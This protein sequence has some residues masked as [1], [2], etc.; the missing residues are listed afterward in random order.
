MEQ[1]CYHVS[2]RDVAVIETGNRRSAAC[3]V[4]L[5]HGWLD[6]A[7]S[8]TSVMTSMAHQISPNIHLCAVDLPGHGLSGHKN[9]DNF[10]SF[11]DYI[12][13]VHQF[14]VTLSAKKKILVGHSLGGLIASCYSAAFPEFVDGLFLIESIGPLAE[15]AENSVLRLRNGVNS[16]VRI[17][18]KPRRGYDSY[19]TALQVRAVHS[20]LPEALV[21]PIV[22]RGI[23]LQDGQWMWRAD[24]KLSSQ[25][26]YRM[27]EAHAE[28][29]LAA[30]QCP[31]Q[32]VLGSHGYS[33]LKTYSRAV[34]PGQT[35]IQQ[36]AGGH[37][38]HL[39][40]PEQVGELLSQFIMK[41]DE[42]TF[43]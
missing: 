29:V 38:C 9:S 17:R 41:I 14:L 25:S 7:A 19:D 26:L 4:V 11:H 5:L 28:A 33:S 12:D 37:H 43:S 35:D 1:H 22:E 42:T 20:E 30:I 16:R 15:S 18:R 36:V 10:Y 13:D 8:F 27:S 6:N 3:S 2:G 31:F 23:G 34:L 21:A 40:H 32:V 24:P 39:E